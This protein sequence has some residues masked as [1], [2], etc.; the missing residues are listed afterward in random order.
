MDDLISRSWSAR[1]AVAASLSHRQKIF[2][3]MAMAISKSFIGLNA[4]ADLLRELTRVCV[5][6]PRL[7]ILRVELEEAKLALG[8]EPSEQNLAW[9]KRVR[10]ELGA[11]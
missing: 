8:E 1:R 11:A 10:S 6:E 9:V 5:D 2:D 3:E 7:A 4:K